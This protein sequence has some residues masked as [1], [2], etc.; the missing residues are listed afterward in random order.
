[1]HFPIVESHDPLTSRVSARSA[2]E[3]THHVARKKTPFSRQA[4]LPEQA[5]DTSTSP[6]MLGAR[7]M[8]GLTAIEAGRDNNPPALTG[9]EP[10]HDD[11]EPT[12]CSPP[13]FIGQTG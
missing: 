6:H 8:V 1:M 3:G 5:R 12:E 11:V 10:P 4:P 13:R 7:A 9:K 2:A